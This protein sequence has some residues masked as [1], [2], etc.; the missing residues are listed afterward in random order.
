MRNN[1]ACGANRVRIRNKLAGV[2]LLAGILFLPERSLA[3]PE[4]VQ[5]THLMKSA[6]PLRMEDL[7]KKQIGPARPH[8]GMV[9]VAHAPKLV[10]KPNTLPPNNHATT[11]WDGISAHLTVEAGIAANPWTK[12]GRNFAQFY[13]DR[14]NTVVLNQIIGTISHPVT[15]IGSGYGLGFVFELMYGSDA[16][17]IPTIGMADGILTG[18]YQLVPLQ[19][20]IDIHT[21]WILPRGIDFQIGQTFGMLGTEGTS[22]L[23]RPFYSYSYAADYIVPFETVGIMSTTHLSDKLD[24][25]LGIDAGNST[26]FGNAGNNNRPKGT[27]GIAFSHF[28]HGKLDGHLIGHFGP[29]GNNGRQVTSTDG[30]TS[31]GM[32]K[33]ANNLMQYNADLQLTY[34]FNDKMSVMLD[35]IYMHDNALRDDLYGFITYFSL[36]INPSLRLNLRGEIFRDNTGSVIASY[37]GPTSNLNALRNRPFAYYIAPPTTYGVLTAG[38]TYRPNFVNKHLNLGTFTIR[39]EIRL[40]KSLNGTRPFNRAATVANPVVRDGTSNMFWFSC[41]AI[42]SF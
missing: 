3:N 31:I 22:A 35:T 7:N 39:P 13:A 33:I 29:Q 9:P 34:H 25:I 19:S 30:W 41:D 17:F 10:T 15:N 32:G 26:T 24:W 40:D 5:G 21:P 28:M 6:K 18:M 1:L 8:R 12:S 37:E 27:A 14:A 38:V 16:R 42:W 23:T 11:Y 4:F 20:H 2:S 36:D